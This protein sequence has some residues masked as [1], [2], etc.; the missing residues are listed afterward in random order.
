M[1]WGFVAVAT[2]TVGGA[3]IAGKGAKEGAEIQAEAGEA[4]IAAQ[5]AA[6][7]S[8]EARTE[9]F[10][11]LGA[12]AIS[13]LQQLLGF[14]ASPEFS[15]INADIDAQIAALRQQQF[16]PTGAAG[17]RAGTTG[18]RNVLGGAR[19][20]GA[21]IQSQIQA[22]E[23]QRESRLS[24]VPEFIQGDRLQGLE[25]INPVVSFLRD[26]G[27]EQIQES[28]AAQGR[29]GAGG[30]LKD[31]TQFNTDLTSTIVPQ[32]Q[33]QRFN[34]LFNVAGLG[35]NVAAGQGTAGLQT[36]TNVSNLLGNVGAAEAAGVAGQTQAI[37]GGLQNIAGAVGAFPNLFGGQP[38]PPVVPRAGGPAPVV[39]ISTFG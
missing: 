33:N 17:G 12:G 18:V 26:Q 4:G 35:A 39:D 13:P 3:L 36:A 22:L 37:T 6:R 2:A 5:T 30:T 14:Q 24:G 28:A 11:Q 8:F 21:D 31:L 10:R 38:P 29:L 9:P 23:T 19:E 7:E 25:E 16:D 27:F 15:S 32:L 34:Q 20:F 1:T